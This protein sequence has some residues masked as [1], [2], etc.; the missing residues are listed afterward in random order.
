MFWLA[1]DLNEAELHLRDGLV[2]LEADVDFAPE[3]EL[4]HARF[5]DIHPQA[6]RPA[7]GI[8]L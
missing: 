7:Q 6:S 2:D 4:D 1:F 3:R 8:R 5:F